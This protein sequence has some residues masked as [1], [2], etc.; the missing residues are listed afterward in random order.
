MFSAFANLFPFIRFVVRGESMMPNFIPGC[1]LLVSRVS[2][3]FHRPQTDDVVIIRDPRNSTRELIKRIVAVPGDK[4]GDIVLHEN[5]YFVAGDNKDHSRDSRS[6]G[7][8]QRNL[9][10]AKVVLKLSA[11]SFPPLDI[12]FVAPY[13]YFIRLWRQKR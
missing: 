2:Y 3:L 1:R 13:I 4:M 9:I 12:S 10:V 5:E 8:I 6:F 7:P 11:L